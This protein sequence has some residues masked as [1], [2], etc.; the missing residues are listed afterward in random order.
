ME[1]DKENESDGFFS[2]PWLRNQ[3]QLV[4][5]SLALSNPLEDL[6]QLMKYLKFIWEIASQKHHAIHSQPSEHLSMAKEGER[7][8]SW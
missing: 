3:A 4:I 5:L 8:M 2:Q 7:E 6:T 1:M